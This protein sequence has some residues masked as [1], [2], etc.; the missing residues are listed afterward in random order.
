MGLPLPAPLPEATW[1]QQ[2]LTA[3]GVPITQ[4]NISFLDAWN[5]AEGNLQGHSGLGINNPFNTTNTMPGSYAVNSAGVQAFAT[6][7]DGIAATVKT[8]K[9]Q[10]S[11]GWTDFYPAIYS[12]L[13]T[14]NPFVD[15]TDDLR[16]QL[17][18]W[19][20]GAG[21]IGTTD[22][23]GG[24]APGVPG[25]TP[26]AEASQ[27]IEGGGGGIS[28]PKPPKIGSCE[29]HNTSPSVAGVQLPPSPMDQL[30]YTLCFIR[31]DLVRGLA[32]VV[33]AILVIL[34]VVIIVAEDL[35]VGPV[36]IKDTAAKVT[37]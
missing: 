33:A 17:G 5:K 34:G 9:P 10:N 27:P 22:T 20:T 29:L 30:Q 14:G 18:T 15:V 19:G 21:F 25:G 23:G 16:K 8:I 13:W 35:K 4:P 31:T 28:L 32:W 26:G 3:L 37:E 1:E 2:L 7:S 11:P 24:T 6:L 12:A 36:S